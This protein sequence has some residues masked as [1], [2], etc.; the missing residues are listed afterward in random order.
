MWP[1][2]NSRSS[3]QHHH[4]YDFEKKIG[5][6]TDSL[7]AYRGTQFLYLFFFGGTM[8]ATV[9]GHRQNKRNNCLEIFRVKAPKSKAIQA[10]I[11]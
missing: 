11:L 4:H 5:E 9:T 6:K 2:L 1:S 3:S 8:T 10:E 7:F